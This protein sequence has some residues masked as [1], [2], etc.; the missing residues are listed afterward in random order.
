M[1]DGS[2]YDGVEWLNAAELAALHIP[3][4][5]QTA[6]GVRLLAEAQGWNTPEREGSIWRNR[7][8]RGGGVEYHRCVLTSHQQAH[9]L[10]KAAPMTTQATAAAGGGERWAWFERQT[11]RTKARARERLA[12][13]HAIYALTDSGIG[14][15]EALNCVARSRGIGI[16]T[17]QQWDGLVRDIPREHWL[18]HLAPGHGGGRPQA[19]CD[20]QAFEFLASLYLKQSRPNLSECLYQTALKAREMGWK[21]PSE[22]TL[23]ARIMALPATTRILKRE[24]EHALKRRLPAQRRDKSVFHAMQAVNTDYHQWD[25]FVAWPDGTKSRPEMVAFQDL[26]SG[27]VL[28]WRIA[29][30]PSWHEVRLA[31]GDVVETYGIPSHCWMDNGHEFASKRITGGQKNRYRFKLRDDE[32]EGLMTALGVQVHFTTP[33]HGQAKPIERAFRDMAQSIARHPAFDGAYAGNSPV[34][35]PAN[36]GQRAVPLEEFLAVV[37]QGIIQHNARP[38]RLAPVCRGRS[39]DDTFN[40][41]YAAATPKWASPEQ[42]RLWLLAAEGVR[43]RKQ[44]GKIVMFGNEYWSPQLLRHQGQPVTVRFDPEKL[45]EPLHVYSLDGRWLCEAPVFAAVGFNDVGAAQEHA[46]LRKGILKHERAIADTIGR[47][48]ARELARTMAKLPEPEAPP[49]PAALRLFTGGGNA[50]R[51]PQAI[52]SHEDAPSALEGIFPLGWQPRVIEGGEPDD[53]HGA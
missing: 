20:D 26:Y 49:S 29:K 34:N 5:P 4:L 1:P 13:I 40:E 23:R 30:T 50:V 31:F 15:T 22:R 8:G 45:H 27:K 37:R 32:P 53:D 21:L 48:G 10:L 14:K 43:V 42:R 9:L 51:K 24:G 41:S 36:Y 11:D 44:D 39:F 17:L 7:E 3:G 47:M 35:K 16:S 2:P 12:A 28:A 19:E 25:V 38:G 33:Y 6:R 18:P 52:E 46:R